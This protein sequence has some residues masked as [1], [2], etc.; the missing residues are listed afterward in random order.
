MLAV[1]LAASTLVCT[2][3]QG[4]AA[5][6]PLRVLTYNIFAGSRGLDGL[7]ETMAQANADLI[8]LQE[9]DVG[10]RRSGRVDEAA[11]LG[12]ALK[13]EHVFVPHFDYQGGEFGL[14]LLSRFPIVRSERVRVKGSTLSL[15][16]ATVRTPRGDVR[17]IVVHFTVTADTRRQ[18]ATD[19]ARLAEATAAHA[20]AAAT[21]GPVLVLG[22]MNDVSGSAA[23]A[24]F[25]KDLQDS[26][27][28]KGEGA[29]KTWNSAY[30]VKRIDYVWAS[31]AFTVESCK[32]V[33]STASDHFPVLA[34]LSLSSD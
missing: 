20:L 1:A 27:E 7:A 14:A 30:P 23:Y 28:L 9:V 12:A 8:A 26:C 2:A 29:V 5:Q 22:D 15:L 6:P 3:P 32:T 16:D 34:E 25:A 18:A 13:M 11:R 31:G 17:A 24:V 21:T 33:Q 19:A 4:A 10:T